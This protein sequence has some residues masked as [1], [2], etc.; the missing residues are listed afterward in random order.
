MATSA[1]P[2]ERFSFYTARCAANIADTIHHFMA[3]RRRMR[4]WR[5][6][7]RMLP[8]LSERRSC[9]RAQP[10]KVHVATRPNDLACMHST[11]LSRGDGSMTAELFHARTRQRI[12][13]LHG[14]PKQAQRSSRS[15]SP[16]TRT[17]RNLIRPGAAKRAP[18]TCCPSPWTRAGRL[19]CLCA[20]WVTWSSHS[21]LHSGKRRSVGA[22]T[23]S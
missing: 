18:P 11:L 14:L 1:R 22:P 23:P 5:A 15:S 21:T 13:D 19:D 2:P 12:D 10:W 20:S 16:A 3:G 6:W 17:W 9:C 7:N 8:K 4:S